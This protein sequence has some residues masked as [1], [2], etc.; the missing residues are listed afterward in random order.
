MRAVHVHSVQA[1]SRGW[2]DGEGLGL[3]RRAQL[4]R[5]SSLATT[6]SP[7]LLGSELGLG[8]TAPALDMAGCVLGMGQAQGGVSQ[9]ESQERNNGYPYSLYPVT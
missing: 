4:M 8:T 3:T 7:R 5:S 2:R 1:K 9:Q 6:Y